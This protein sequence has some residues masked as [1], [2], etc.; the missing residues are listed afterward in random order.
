M[1]TYQEA[2][3]KLQSIQSEY[4]ALTGIDKKVKASKSKSKAG[5]GNGKFETVV[6][7]KD[8]CLNVLVTHK[9]TKSLFEYSLYA[10]NG[11]I[12]K[13]DWLKLRHGLVS[14]F[15]RDTKEDNLTLRAYLSNL[16]SKIEAVKAIA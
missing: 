2:K 1:T 12:S 10:K 5:N 9:E 7:Q 15:E 3:D 8:D 11:K 16:K 14:Q 6:K 13:E 4:Q